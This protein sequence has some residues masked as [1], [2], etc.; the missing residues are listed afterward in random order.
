MTSTTLCKER[1]AGATQGW[2]LT[3]ANWL[4]VIATSV[5]APILPQ[6]A[7]H[8]ESDAHVEVLWGL[9]A[10][11]PALFV[12]ICA[13]PAG[14]L[15]EKFGLR[16]LLLV[17]VGLYGVAGCAPMILNN[18]MGIVVSRACVG[19]LEA[20]IMTCTTALVADYFHG[21]IRERWFA[22][23]TGGASVIATGMV[24]L[25][26]IMGQS[27]WR[28]PFAMYGIGFVLFPLCVFKIWEPTA[29]ERSTVQQSH[30][31]HPS[32]VQHAGE[33]FNWIPMAPIFLLTFFAGTAFYV[34]LV[35]LAFILTERGIAAGSAIGVAM[36]IMSVCMS[37]GA[38]IFKYLRIPVAGKL[39]ISFT[40]SAIGFFAVALSHTFVMTTVGSSITGLGSGMVL[41]TLITWALS[42]LPT[43]VRARGTGIWQSCFFFGQFSSPQIILFLKNNWGGLSNAVMLYGIFMTIAAIGAIGAYFRTGS[44][45]LVEAEYNR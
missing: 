40:L 18:L 30:D 34:L 37:L 22:I 36:A 45:L 32:S 2:T 13:W 20:I 33:R 16:A 7:K 9:V 4:S 41:P 38:V 3:S 23:Q 24:L 28:F 11:I 17:G 12:A 25:G 39:T 5:L 19:I 14:L 35:Q 42:K 43:Q 21:N 8:F 6:I 1:T 15:A 44:Q 27:S 10:T 31:L 26:G 29:Q